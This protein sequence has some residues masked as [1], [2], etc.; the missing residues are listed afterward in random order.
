MSGALT[1]S[2]GVGPHVAAPWAS[3][4]LMLGSRAAHWSR[5]HSGQQLV[6]AVSV[7]A[8]DFAAVLIGCGWMMASPAPRLPPVREVA[9]SIQPGAPVRIVT[10]TRIITDFFDWIGTN[11]DRLR[12]GRQWQL[13][14]VLA[15]TPLRSLKVPQEQPLP[16]PGVISR[17]AGLDKEWAAR[18]CQPPADL[19]F[20]G[21][22][23]WL[24][25]DVSTF[26]G[27]GNER[28]PIAQ[29]LLPEAPRVATWSTR[30]YAASRLDM[31]LPPADVRAVVLDGASATSYLAAIEASV[32][33][34]V[35]DR[36]VADESAPERVLNYRN[37]RGQ[38]LSVEREV[39]WAP[40]P[41]VETL[42]FV[43]PL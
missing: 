1:L 31:Q 22:L 12:V 17:M 26:L 24:R 39:R 23:K 37:T 28:E 13:D 7:P 33:I 21:T 15:M 3:R 29:I 30:L 9:T 14:K 41:G 16:E 25:Q 18:L 34:V 40:P 10:R 35:L 36:S 6:I 2:E 38:P 11:R 42:G 43:V 27:R 5:S 20:A 32:V 19:A 8:R 4:L